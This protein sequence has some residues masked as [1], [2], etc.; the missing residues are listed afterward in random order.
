MP[1]GPDT[2]RS[3]GI[4]HIGFNP[5]YGLHALRAH[6]VRGTRDR[7]NVSIPHMG[8]MPYGPVDAPSDA[9]HMRAS[10]QSLIWVACPTGLS[11]KPIN[12][13]IIGSFNPSYGLHALRAELGGAPGRSLVGARC[14]NPSY[15]LHA[16]RAWQVTPNAQ[17][18]KVSIPHMGCMPYGPL[19]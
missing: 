7:Q 17:E 9:I 12:S 2:F 18:S 13:W 6:A 8:C 15:G 16:L 4:S 10:F 11:T 3:S 14:F 19:L 5:S 1:Y